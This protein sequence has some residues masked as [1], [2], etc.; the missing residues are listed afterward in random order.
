VQALASYK[1][2]LNNYFEQKENL[3]LARQVFEVIRLQYRSGIKTYL[4]VITANNDLFAAQIN[5]TNA[6][7]Q[8]MS[9]KIDVER[10]LGN[11]K[12]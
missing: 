11:L 7:Y 1:A 6:L 10:A 4:E 3:D 8:V 2:N 12:Y 5:F 9:N